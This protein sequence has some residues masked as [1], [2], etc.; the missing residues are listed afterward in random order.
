[1]KP[2]RYTFLIVP[3]HDGKNRQFSISRNGTLVL[4]FT[5][6]GIITS[7]VIGLLI[8]G[9]K[10]F[11][12]D[13][14]NNRYTEV[15]NEVCRISDYSKRKIEI[16]LYNEKQKLIGSPL[17]KGLSSNSSRINLPDKTS[18]SILARLVLPT[19]IVPSTA[20]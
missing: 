7:M 3:D 15:I 10:A 20:I 19:P 5:I 4:I 9:P 1:M 2:S 6:V 11:D 8:F 14:M 16:K 17:R 18:A 12:H 13:R